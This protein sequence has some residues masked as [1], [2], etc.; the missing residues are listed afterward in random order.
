[1]KKLFESEKLWQ[2]NKKANDMLES[3]LHKHFGSRRNWHSITRQ[4]KRELTVIS[5]LKRDNLRVPWF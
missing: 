3:A 5:H 2:L 4:S 1:M